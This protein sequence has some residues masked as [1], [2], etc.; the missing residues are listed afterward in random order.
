MTSSTVSSE[1]APRSST[2]EASLVTSS[3]FTPSC[4]ATMALTCCSILLIGVRVLYEAFEPFT[5]RPLVVR[6]GGSQGAYSSLRPREV[7]HFQKLKVIRYLT[8]IH[9]MY[10]P[11]LTCN[12]SPVM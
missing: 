8:A 6:W 2:K 1:S 7:Q 3:S 10:M 5:N 12:V 9:T 11:P 4:S